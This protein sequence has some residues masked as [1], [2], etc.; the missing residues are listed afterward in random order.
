MRWNVELVHKETGETKIMEVSSNTQEMA[1]KIAQTT[2]PEHVTGRVIAIDYDEVA[3]VSA[4]AAHRPATPGVAAPEEQY[5]PAESSAPAAPSPLVPHPAPLVPR[6]RRLEFDGPYKHARRLTM[7]I[8]VLMVIAFVFAGGMVVLGAIFLLTGA[9]SDDPAVVV[10]MS[11]GGSMLLWS[12]L[13][14][15]F[16]VLFTHATMWYLGTMA[17]TMREVLREV[18]LLREGR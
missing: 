11:L 16:L 6:S 10:G 14:A 9:G 5:A 2:H 15:L 7:V 3:A 18:E 12:G 8:W 17:S 4:T 13:Y 1:R